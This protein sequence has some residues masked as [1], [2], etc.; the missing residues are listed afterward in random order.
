MLWG[1][2]QG[3]GA[4]LGLA[5]RQVGRPTPGYLGAVTRALRYHPPRLT[6]LP[7]AFKVLY[8][9][10]VMLT[11]RLVSRTGRTMVFPIGGL[12][13]LT[14]S[15]LV[16]AFGG[17]TLGTGPLA[18]LMLWSG[19]FFGNTDYD[20]W[21]VADIRDTLVIVDKCLAMDQAWEFTYRS[22]W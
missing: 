8:G 14:A 17:D 9:H 12:A 16:F 11:G 3:G 5:E 15:L 18:F 20:E 2:S 10:N 6:M 13:V 7:A 22:S 21:Y 4:A 1:H 19:F